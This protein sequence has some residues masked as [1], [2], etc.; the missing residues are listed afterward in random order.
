MRMCVCGWENDS[1]VTR[2][3]INL[4]ATFAVITANK[5]PSEKPSV[6]LTRHLSYSD[7]S[8]DRRLYISVENFTSRTIMSRDSPHAL[9]PLLFSSS[10]YISDF[11]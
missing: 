2:I 7:I 9:S 1:N 4:L 8:H 6:I 11:S 10:Y 5:N 3:Y